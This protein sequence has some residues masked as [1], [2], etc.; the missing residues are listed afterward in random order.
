MRRLTITIP[1]ATSTETAEAE[2]CCHPT[3]RWVDPQYPEDPAFYYVDTTDTL[4]L[5]LEFELACEGE[6]VELDEGVT[7]TIGASTFGVTAPDIAL[8]G[9]SRWSAT[10]PV[11]AANEEGAVIIQI[12]GFDGDGNYIVGPYLIALDYYVPD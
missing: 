9:T 12:S 11:G 8:T 1:R 6:Q 4:P 2:E 5:E 7:W 10:V 3:A